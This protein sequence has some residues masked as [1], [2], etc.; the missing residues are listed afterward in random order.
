MK[1][2]W[3]GVK[4]LVDVDVAGFFENIDHDILLKLLR[5]RI[6]D[7]RF[8]DLIRDMLKA[9]VMEGRAHTQTYSGTPQG[10]IVSPILANIY[11]HELDE[12][13]AGRIT[14]FE[15]GKTRATNPEYRRLAGRIAKR[16]ERLKRLEASDNAD[17]VTVKAILAE[18]NTLSKQM[19][20]L[21]S[22]DAMDAGFAD[23][24]T[25]VTPTIFLSV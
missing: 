17:Q 15:K 22:R 14:A 1:A 21:P 24:A 11:L 4:W 13:M 7:E 8:I 10:G 2:V 19:R 20:S 18:I 25:A 6:D 12:F 23:F 5:K 3:T 9:G 16:R